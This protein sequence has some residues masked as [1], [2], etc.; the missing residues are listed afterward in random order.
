[1][2]TLYNV[3]SDDGF[4]ARENGDEDFIPDELWDDFLVL[5]GQNE[6]VVMGKETYW[7]VQEYPRNLIKRFESLDLRRVV[8]TRDVNFFAKPGYVVLSS[9]EDVL[10]LG[11]NIL[12][13][14][15]PTLNAVFLEKALVDRVIL[16]I[17]PKRIGS[18][19]KAF[20]NEPNLVLEKE[21]AKSQGGKWQ[22]YL[23]KK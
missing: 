10:A 5:C 14:S 20:E 19:I 9:P 3:V 21:E 17:L 22:F 15:G 8:V 13:S 16:N 6:T 7:S 1:M 12:I 4:V 2:V 23:V 18:G 11:G